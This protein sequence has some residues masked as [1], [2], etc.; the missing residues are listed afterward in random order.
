VWVDGEK[1]GRAMY[2]ILSNAVDSMPG[3]GQVMIDTM[4][5]NGTL[6]IQCSDN[7]CGMPPEIRRKIFEPFMTYG[8]KRGTGLGMA[9]VK[10]I[11]DGI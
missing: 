7:G 8:K 1:I 3:G 5:E 10:K 9:I 6:V 11:I 4:A 2:N